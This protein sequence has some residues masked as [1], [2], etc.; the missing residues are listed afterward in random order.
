M[1]TKIMALAGILLALAALTFVFP[2]MTAKAT[3]ETTA[4]PGSIC[5]INKAS[6]N[7]WGKGAP[8]SQEKGMCSLSVHD[9]NYCCNYCFNTQ[10]DNIVGVDCACL[11]YADFHYC[12]E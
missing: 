2:V 5:I 4:C 7:A 3:M 6:E 9:C 12:I 10:P 8:N 11:D 1:K